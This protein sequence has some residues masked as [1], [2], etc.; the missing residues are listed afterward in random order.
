MEPC[1]KANGML[2]AS[3]NNLD[4]LHDVFLNFVFGVESVG[5]EVGYDISLVGVHENNASNEPDTLDE[6]ETATVPN[7]AQEPTALDSKI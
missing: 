6:M 1:E 5:C 2:E 3:C 4:V 7:V